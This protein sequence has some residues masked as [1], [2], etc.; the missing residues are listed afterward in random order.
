MDWKDLGEAVA[1]IGLPLLGAVLPVP[2]GAAIGAAL[3]SAIGAGSA[4]PEDI[5]ASLTA[6]S[7]AV[8][9]AK[10]FEETHQ[11]TMMSLQLKYETD[12]YAAQVADRGSARMMQTTTKASIVPT[13]AFIIVGS[14]IALVIG[15]L[16]GYAKVDSAL[17][18]TL[19]GYLSA[20]CEQVIAFYFGSSNSS[21]QKDVLIANSTP[22]V[23]PVK[24]V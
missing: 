24:K 18:G 12:M 23:A 2:G 1:K 4:A 13:L 8:L 21:Q 10:Q 19:V 20:K 16:M 6:S 14:F 15:T 9:K 17:A 7:D 5:L 22:I 11:E 3:A